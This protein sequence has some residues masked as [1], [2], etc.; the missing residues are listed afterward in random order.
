VHFDPSPLPSTGPH[1]N[2]DYGLTL[3]SAAAPLHDASLIEEEL[4]GTP[5][6]IFLWWGY[7]A[8]SHIRSLRATWPRA[9]FV[10]CLDT[11]PDA[12]WLPGEIKEWLAYARWRVDGLVFASSTMRQN[13][14]KLA[15]WYR[16]VPN[17][18]IPVVFPRATHARS[19]SVLPPS[20]RMPETDKVRIC[21]TGRSD[22]LFSKDV[23]MRKDA[24]GGRLLALAEVGAEVWVSSLGSSERPAFGFQRMPLFTNADI[25][26]GLMATYLSQFTG[27]LVTYNVHNRTIRRRVSSGLS[28]RLALAA[29]VPVAWI[30]HPASLD[31]CREVWQSHS[32]AV[33][34]ECAPSDVLKRLA[35]AESETRAAWS[36]AQE[37]LAIENYLP[38][39]L[40]LLDRVAA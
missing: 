6:V 31:L 30:V 40:T 14:F 27:N 35:A 19:T 5:D 26:T 12:R 8:L 29:A 34:A 10:L 37:V 28:T 23:H 9:K 39:L 36:S 25:F 16:L 2:L 20:L 22:F 1:A 3:P 7:K 4:R 13:F 21:F 24:L 18:C 11:L 17:A 32:P 33:V 15:P 38:D